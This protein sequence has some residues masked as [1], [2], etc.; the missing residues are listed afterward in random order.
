MKHTEESQRKGGKKGQK[1]L[2]K[3]NMHICTT[4]A[5]KQQGSEG[6]GQ[7]GN[8]VEGVIRAKKGEIYNTFSNKDLNNNNKKEIALFK[9]KV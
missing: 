8:W 4:Y 2:T 5:H 6:L 7:S 3:E 9:G 1:R